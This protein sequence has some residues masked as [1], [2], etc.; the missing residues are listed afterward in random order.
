MMLFESMKLDE[1]IY[2]EYTYDIIWL[3]TERESEREREM[4]PP[5]LTPELHCFAIRAYSAG[6]ALHFSAST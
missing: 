2:T 3:H 6:C 1:S 5:S 4:H